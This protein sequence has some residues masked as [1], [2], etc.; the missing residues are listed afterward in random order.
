MTT[1]NNQ[2]EFL[3]ALQENPEWREAV[4]AQILGEELLQLPAAFQAFV[5]RITAS[6]ER[7]ETSVR[8]LEIFAAEMKE[9]TAEMKEFTAEMKEFTA[10]MKEFVIRQEQF[11]SNTSGRFN[12]MEGD[13]SII[14]GQFAQSRISRN[15]VFITD[16]L[17]LDYVRQL[18]SE[19][20]SRMAREIAGG[21]R[22]T[23]ELK[24]FRGADLIIE[25]RDQGQ[26]KY[27]A[28][29]VSFTADERD[30]SRAIRNAGLLEKLTGCTAIAVVASVRNAR[31][32]EERIAANDL[33]WHSV[34]EHALRPN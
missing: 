30:S 32:V 31:E 3:Q 20:L 34:S 9:F 13:I 22:L 1:I 7:L 33:V 19:D 23:D 27:I 14:K 18:T 11:N 26:T 8:N 5:E 4:R 28:V 25:A 29:E 24:S 6:T 10:E 2:E 15:A 12:R 16:D 17:E 21:Y